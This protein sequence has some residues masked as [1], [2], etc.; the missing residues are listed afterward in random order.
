M[1]ESPLEGTS[2]SELAAW[3]WSNG[4]WHTG[5]YETYLR[6]AEAATKVLLDRPNT[7]WPDRTDATE[8]AYF[9]WGA[10]AQDKPAAAQA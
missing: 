4:N 8:R 3:A 9:S 5:R 6:W 10:S 7:N 2:P 1:T